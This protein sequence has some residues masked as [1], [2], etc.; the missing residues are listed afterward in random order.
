MAGRLWRDT[1]GILGLLKLLDEHQEAVEY[2]LITMGLR[3]EDLGH[4]LQ[5]RDLIVIIR[6]AQPGS[7]IYRARNPYHE[8]TLARQLQVA[9][10]NDA[11]RL[12]WLYTAAHSKRRPPE[13]EFIRFPW[14]ATASGDAEVIKGDTFESAQDAADWYAERFPERAD[15]VQ[16]M[17]ERMAT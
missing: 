16:Q 15:E 11:R 3:L 9:Q 14:D 7:A 13:P 4:S 2:D 10:I 17:A 1:G 12:A 5:W 8:W 6:Q